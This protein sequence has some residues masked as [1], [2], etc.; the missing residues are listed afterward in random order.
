MSADA[1]RFGS[2]RR[3]WVCRLWV[4]SAELSRIRTEGQQKVQMMF[5]SKLW[6]WLVVGTMAWAHLV[7]VSV[8]AVE[9]EA[10]VEQLIAEAKEL[11]ELR[12]PAVPPVW[13]RPHPQMAAW[14]PQM[15]RP[16]LERLTQKF[17]GNDYRDSYVR[18]HLMWAVQRLLEVEF[19]QFRRTGRHSVPDDV[20]PRFVKLVQA[21][22]EEIRGAYRLWY[23]HEPEDIASQYHSL[24][25]ATYIKVGFPP[26]ERE[27]WGKNSL[28]HHPLVRQEEIKQIL[29]EMD[30]LRPLF[31]TI[32]DKEAQA[33]N[34][35]I[36]KLNLLVREY[37][38]DLIYAIIQTGEP[39]ML[40]LVTREIG[41]QVDRKQWIGL[42]LMAYMYVAA[43]DG[44]LAL[45]DEDL[46]IA[47]GKELAHIA[48]RAREYVGYM[49]GHGPAPDW[50]VP[51]H[52]SFAD[53]AYH[54]VQ[55][56]ETP[57]T[58][59]QFIA[60]YQAPKGVGIKQNP[61]QKIA[62]EDLTIDH[63]R[64]AISAATSELYHPRSANKNLI[65]NYKIRSY[66]RL[67]SLLHHGGIQSPEYQEI[68]HEI[69]NH[70]LVCWAMISA[71][72]KYQDPRLFKRIN[73]VL[74]SDI[75]FTY[76]RA[77]RSLLLSNLSADR[78]GNYA[79]RD[80]KWLV[81]ALSDKGNWA[82]EYYGGDSD[83]W[84]DHAN[85]QYGV[86][87]L[88][89][90]Q[91]S[92]VDIPT[93]VWKSIDGHW[94][95]T[96]QQTP[97]LDPAGW[98]VG[99][100]NV[101]GENDGELV[102]PFYQAV[103]APMTAGG[104]ATLTLT[105]RYLY[106]PKLTSVGKD[107]VS[108]ALRKGIAWLNNS[109]DPNISGIDVDWFYYMWTMQRVGQ[110]T[111]IRTFND[112]DWFRQ[113]TAEMLNRQGPDGLWRDPTGK[114]GTLLSTG[115]ALLY[116]GNALSPIAVSK[117]QFDGNWNNRPNDLWNFVE[118][119][120]SELEATTTWQIVQLDQPLYQLVESPLLYLA[121]DQPIEL[122]ADQ[123]QRLRE[124]LTAGGMLVTN[125]ESSESGTARSF[126][127]LAEKLFPG[128]SLENLPRDHP[129]FHVYRKLPQSV[130]VMAI[131]SGVRP[132]MVHFRKDL[133]KGLQANDISRADGFPALANLYLYS[134]DRNPRRVRLETNFVGPATNK[135]SRTLVGA[136]IRYDGQ[137]DPEPGAGTQLQRLLA[138]D[139]D[140]ALTMD[141]VAAVDLNTHKF[142]LLSAL[143]DSQLT[144]EEAAAIRR[145]VEAGGTLWM[146][147]AGGSQGAVEALAAMLAKIMPGARPE[148]LEPSDPIISGYYA[149]ERVRYR[150]YV[151]GTMGA[152]NTP[153]LTAVRQK[154][155][156]AIIYSPEDLT[157]GL[158][159]LSHW[160]IFGYSVESARRLVLNGVLDVLQRYNQAP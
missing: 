57:D 151:L 92:G 127:N 48:Q 136:R 110:A 47:V 160:G 139:H 135:P 138:R 55:L 31:K 137:F 95:H 101:E 40:K 17:T 52:R 44:Y 69:G 8:A 70:S 153:R 62:P 11:D 157:G 65:P 99:M 15:G 16:V 114:Q 51:N 53:Y 118:H 2:N 140:L 85:G 73:W 89:A 107:N 19:D 117:V 143:G 116:L 125:P 67:W 88:W 14:D 7:S 90:A 26:F 72:E 42:D 23:R 33:Y 149:N 3:H 75:P 27:Y 120:S 54:M 60:R 63:I 98:T 155:R 50:Y 115:F 128:R 145:W 154:G 112:V 5:H 150:S 64:R 12:D 41:K 152:S 34:N 46:L 39:D 43:Y 35:R 28:P 61:D 25:A 102:P 84:G 10:V 77:M 59:R 97:A 56:L 30:R 37:R 29:V 133:S 21:M 6:V 76:D 144:D 20:G 126:H 36:T 146:D 103:S 49:I 147:A 78:W 108:P 80:L 93:S 113:V 100:L 122:A 1:G 104:V 38:G 94:R 156:T 82:G 134:V 58:V 45:Y 32:Y 123:L 119:I 83:G 87:G 109:F 18:W 13:R 66:R 130:Q 106:G 71:G 121:S 22:P 24:N 4:L 96:Q 86:L 91:R 142:A 124:Y 111:G 159:G 74:S 79:R 148:P 132:L 131:D 81:G 158:A 9:L 68:V 105:E 129:V 141:A